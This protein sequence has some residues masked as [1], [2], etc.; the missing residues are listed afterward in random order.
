M[1][2][3]SAGTTTMTT[4]LSDTQAAILNNA[5]EWDDGS[6]LPLPDTL[7]L[8]L[9]LRRSLTSLIERGFAQEVDAAAEVPVW[10]T[11][12]ERPLALVITEAGRAAVEQPA[13]AET[14]AIVADTVPDGTGTR[15]T[16]T[17]MI[18]G[19]LRRPE[20]ATVAEIMAATGWL[21]HTTRGA[22]SGL[23]RKGHVL[24]KA[25]RDGATAYLIAQA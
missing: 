5:A 2:P 11:E 8:S 24:D 23:R 18:L 6:L 25:T 20:G 1:G 3:R 17:A 14:A 22:L 7:K 19:M 16:K 15:V 10:R 12:G 13:P 4:K 9:G 21:P